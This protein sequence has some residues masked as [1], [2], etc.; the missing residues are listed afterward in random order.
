MNATKIEMR[1]NLFIVE[2]DPE[3]W[4]ANAVEEGTDPF[5]MRKTLL[6]SPKAK[7]SKS[8]YKYMS[9]PIAQLKGKKP[10]E[11]SDKAAQWQAKINEVLNKPK[12][13][14]SK[15]KAKLDGS[16]VSTQ[17]V[18]SGNPALP[19]LYRVQ[20]FDSMDSVAAKKRPVKSQY[21]LFRTISENPA[22]AQGWQHPGIAPGKMLTELELW[23]GATAES[24]L[25]KMIE[26]EIQ[27][28]L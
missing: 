22:K 16:V 1:E 5:D 2:I 19:G 18:V 7:T 12:F 24:L 9:I 10:T 15:L 26:E 28:V 13:G 6:T 21:I 20:T 27:K 17:P 8:G 25:A 14:I 11:G 23:L 4:L 3:N